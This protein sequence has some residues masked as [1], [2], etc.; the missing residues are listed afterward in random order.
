MSKKILV[1]GCGGDIGQSICKILIELGHQVYG[2][3]ISNKNAAQFII[4]R[5]ET[6]LKCTD[7]DYLKSLKEYIEINS[8]D[9]IIPAS[10]P[11]I[12]FFTSNFKSD[13]I[14]N[15]AKLLMANHLSRKIGFDKLATCDY[16]KE[17]NLP[18]PI[19]YQD[20]KKDIK[21]P[22]F[23]KSRTGS[24][25]KNIFKVE[26]RE[27]LE[28]IY[29]KY[30]NF[31]F[32]N[33]LDNTSGE[34]TCCVF[35]SSKNIT[36]TIIFKR[37]LTGGYSGYGEIVENKKIEKLLLELAS[38]L[39]LVGSINVQLRIHNNLPTIFEINPRFSSTVLFRHMF[40][41]EDV[42]WSIE[43]LENNDLSDYT[44]PITGRKFYKGFKEYIK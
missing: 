5:F 41:F 33:Y 17:K 28:F 42:K 31:I 25:S 12:R 10:E 36:R 27:E 30:D 21:F 44:K 14:I 22:I 2:I 38:H 9:I 23:A 3:D 29:K 37:E 7:L 11:E 34:F 4:K 43:D 40:K 1:T 8:I 24:G 19:V 20:L 15:G 26:D 35:K 6:G 13:V 39:R 16:L 18:F 32:Q